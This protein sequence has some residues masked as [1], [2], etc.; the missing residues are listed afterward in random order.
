MLSR[1]LKAAYY[2]LMKYPMRLN[3]QLYKAV[4]APSQTHGKPVLVHLGPGQ[5]NYLEGWYNLNS[6]FISARSDVWANLEDPL[7][8]RDGT[9]DIF[10]SHHVVEHLEDRLIV[11]H[12]KEM[13]RALKPGGAIRVC[14]PNGDI[15]IQKFL[16]NDK[17]WFV[18]FPDAH[19][20][21]GG[22][23]VNFLLCRNEHFTILTR[24]YLEEIAT[25]A[26]FVDAQFPLAGR[27]TS[28]PGRIDARIMAQEAWSS[29]TH[30]HTIVI[31][32]RKPL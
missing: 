17:A 22:K 29:E 13:F 6:N 20:S 23:L 12:F 31:E 18:D 5:K 1:R 26:G 15:A 9:V 4:R 28:M 19:D 16:E 14:G 32:A 7:P 10:Y 21:I 25:Q 30:P 3:G 24:S 11:G 2:V 27:A 8:F